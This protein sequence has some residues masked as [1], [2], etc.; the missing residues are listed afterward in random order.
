MNYYSF[1]EFLV[2]SH[3]SVQSM[4]RSSVLLQPAQPVLIPR[5]SYMSFGISE[6]HTSCPLTSVS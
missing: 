5:V 1:L 6:F 2:A 3:L 4:K